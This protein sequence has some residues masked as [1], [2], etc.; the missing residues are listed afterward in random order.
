MAVT[1]TIVRVGP[2]VEV[3]DVGRERGVVRVVAGVVGLWVAVVLEVP[4]VMVASL[5]HPRSAEGG[6]SPHC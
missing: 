2:M 6:A 3:E 1:S 4:P 5:L